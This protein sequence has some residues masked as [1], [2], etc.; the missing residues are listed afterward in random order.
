MLEVAAHARVIDAANNQIT[1]FPSYHPQLTACHR[2]VLTKNLLTALPDT[3]SKM[4][5]LRVRAKSHKNCM[6]A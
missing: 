1:E 4:T 2:L 6:G 5:H 3:I